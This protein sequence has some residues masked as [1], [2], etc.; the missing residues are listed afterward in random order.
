MWP[1]RI[2]KENRIEFLCIGGPS[3]RLCTQTN[4]FRQ[5][6]TMEGECTYELPAFAVNENGWGP[7]TP[8]DSFNGLPYSFFSRDENLGMIV[9]LTQASFAQ[10]RGCARFSLLSFLASET[11]LGDESFTTVDVSR[12]SS[13]RK[14]KRATSLSFLTRSDPHKDQPQLQQPKLQQQRSGHKQ[15]G[16]QPAE[17]AVQQLPAPQLRYAPHSFHSCFT[18]RWR[19]PLDQAFMEKNSADGL[20]RSRQADHEGY[21]HRHHLVALLLLGHS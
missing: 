5:F 3:N 8:L 7:S 10:N 18:R 19:L 21:S 4:H 20:L 15:Q 14:T 6:F 1:H 2:P 9:D 16:T 11:E 13:T 17:E 12:S